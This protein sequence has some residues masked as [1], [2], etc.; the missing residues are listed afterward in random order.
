MLSILIGNGSTQ[1]DFSGAGCAN[2]AGYTVSDKPNINFLQW[3]T[4]SS[5]KLQPILQIKPGC[6]VY[7]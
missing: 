2:D 1:I 4:D 3:T 6:P 7:R 5:L